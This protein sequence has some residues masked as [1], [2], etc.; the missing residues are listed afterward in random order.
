MDAFADPRPGAQAVV[1]RDDEAR[2]VRQA[3]SRLPDRQRATLILKVYH[4]LTPRGGGRDPGLDGGNGEGQPVSR[5]R[6]TCDA[7]CSRRRRRSHDGAPVGGVG[8]RAGDG[9]RR[10]PRARARGRAAR[11]ARCGS[12]RA[13]KRSSRCG[14]PRCP[15]PSPLYWQA[16][17]SGVQ[18][19]IAEEKRH[20]SLWTR[21]A[22][23]SPPRRRSSRC[24]GAARRSR[25]RSC[26][27]SLPAWSPLPAVEEDAGLRVLEGLALTADGTRTR[28]SRPGSRRT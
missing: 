11:R 7:R 22:S 16:L 21:A 9:R 20:A 8:G 28:T 10:C 27:P 15:E 6:A 2:R 25:R 12:G 14:A 13:A 1:E 17:R 19:R 5:A 18:R 23:R 3:V 26:T 24:S 4:D